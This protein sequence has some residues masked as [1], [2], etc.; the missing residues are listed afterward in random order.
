VAAHLILEGLVDEGLELVRVVHD[1]H[2]GI[3][4]DPWDEVEC[5]HHYARSMSSWAVLLA[6]S[7]ASAD[8]AAGTLEF[9]PRLTPDD[10]R[11][12]FTAGTAWGGY[13]QRLRDG[14][15]ETVI[16]IDGGSFR[17]RRLA[18][19]SVPAGLQPGAAAVRLGADG[20][21]IPARAVRAAE[22]LMVELDAPC[23]LPAGSVLTVTIGEAEADTG[24]GAML[25]PRASE[26]R[27]G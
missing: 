22:G 13:E 11:S 25:S 9:R 1:R 4:R 8:V 10:F 17:L 19:G 7:G 5:G 27:A 2:D 21:P 26:R 15:L 20:P 14:V 18:L 6:L 12:L 3:R 23:E 16:E 24:R